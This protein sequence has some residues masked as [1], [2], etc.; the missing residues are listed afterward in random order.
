LGDV[1]N[2]KRKIINERVTQLRI[3]NNM[4]QRD[5]AEKLTELST[6]STKLSY[7]NISLWENNRRSIPLAYLAPLRD[8]FH[9]TEPYLLGM[10]DDPTETY[11]DIDESI[12]NNDDTKYEILSVQLYAYH[13]MPVFVTFPE[14]D[15]ND[16]WA[17]YNRDTKLFVF[18]NETIKQT[19]LERLNCH[20]YVRDITLLDDPLQH[21]K[22]ID[23]GHL[24]ECDRVYVRMRTSDSY[25]HGLYDGWYEHNATHTALQNNDGLVLPY[26]GLKKTYLAY[27]YLQKVNNF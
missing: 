7:V 22:S 12:K 20:Y 5:L 13:A 24:M 19:T 14:Y 17:L 18:L 25:I 8:V 21:R 10:T 3:D 4:N 27:A 26:S 2:G 1:R 9:V 6:K 11:A 23:M 16:E 15:H